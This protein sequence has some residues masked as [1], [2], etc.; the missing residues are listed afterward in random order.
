MRLQPKHVES[1]ESQAL[2]AREASDT[3]STCLHLH[4][5]AMAVRV[6][7]GTQQKIANCKICRDRKESQAQPDLLMYCRSAARR[8]FLHAE[9]VE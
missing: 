9:D 8:L 7:R 6:P 1:W 4:R 3:A 5:C 2:N